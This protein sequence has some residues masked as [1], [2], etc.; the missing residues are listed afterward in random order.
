MDQ[1]DP[2]EKMDPR[3]QRVVQVSQ[4]MPVLLA[5]LV[6]RVNLEFPDCQDTQEDK[7]QRDLRVSK[8]SLAPTERKELGEQQ[9]SLAHA[10]R[11][12][13]RVLEEKEDQEDQQGKPDQRVT[14]EMMAHQ[15][16]QARGVCQD[17]R[18]QQVSQDQRALLDLQGK[19][20]CPDIPDREERPDSKARP[21]LL[22]LQAWLDLRDQ[23]VRLD[24]WEIAATLDPQAHPV[25]RVYLELQGKK[26]PRVIPV[27]LAQLV[28]MVLLGQEVSPEREDCLAL[29]GLTA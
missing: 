9:G 14:Q 26:E 29:W 24:Q 2:E 5:Q 16:L 3:D 12:D 21:A 27:P 8:V 6:R 1:Q 13:Q 17:L 15:D 7:D 10:D 25:S 4:E 23:Q 20:D 11:E 19:T 18:D 22:V 28:R